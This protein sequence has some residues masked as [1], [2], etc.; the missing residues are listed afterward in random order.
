M[1]TV[2][3][4]DDFVNI[5]KQRQNKD[6][7]VEYLNKDFNDFRLVINVKRVDCLSNTL[8]E[9]LINVFVEAAPYFR[10]LNQKG[11]EFYLLSPEHI[12][13]IEILVDYK[14]DLMAG[15]VV[16][17]S[18]ILKNEIREES[19]L[20]SLLENQVP[21][22]GNTHL[23]Y[24][25]ARYLLPSFLANKNTTKLYSY[26][27][28][29]NL[30]KLYDF[31]QTD[32]SHDTWEKFYNGASRF[33][34]INE[35]VFYMIDEDIKQA[36]IS[37]ENILSHPYM[38]KQFPPS[39]L[40]ILQLFHKNKV[41]ELTAQK[42]LDRL[43]SGVNIVCFNSSFQKS[44]LSGSFLYTFSTVDE[45]KLFA[46]EIFNINLNVAGNDK[47]I[48]SA[49]F[50]SML[51]KELNIPYKSLQILHY[52]MLEFGVD[53]AKEFYDFGENRNWDNDCFFSIDAL[54]K[55]V[56]FFKN[57]KDVG[58]LSIYLGIEGYL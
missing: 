7:V 47:E 32:S 56:E 58:A 46:K 34:S 51:H 3:F 52:L 13:F 35:S 29:I 11:E 43:N 10:D 57:N 1:S 26:K 20:K 17:L 27:S 21:V 18:S 42:Y 36:I 37:Y 2:V 15:K 22:L 8:L 31:I 45:L 4:N 23:I 19:F 48:D 16:I 5:E 50:R 40:N 6:L 14:R 41:L 39:F 33:V 55:V 38:L 30:N 24:N 28:I 49:V 12:P 53:D 9:S 44:Y 54:N 25:S